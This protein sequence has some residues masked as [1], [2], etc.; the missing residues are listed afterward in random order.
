VAV[1]GAVLV[2]C[3]RDPGQGALGYLVGVEGLRDAEIIVAGG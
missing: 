1:P 3:H 2:A